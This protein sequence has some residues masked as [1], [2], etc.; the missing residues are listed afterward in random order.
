MSGKGTVYSVT[1]VNMPVAPG[2]QP[3]Y[4]SALVELDEQPGLRIM[5]NV[6]DCPEDDVVIGLRVEVTFHDVMT[7]D[8]EVEASLPLSRPITT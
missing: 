5:T 6:I 7:D 8:G 4:N 3:P 1:F 2:F